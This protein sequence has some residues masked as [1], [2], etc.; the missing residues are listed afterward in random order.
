MTT[1]TET[2][3]IQMRVDQDCTI[4]IHD[5]RVNADEIIVGAT[6]RWRWDWEVE[7]GHADRVSNAYTLVWVELIDHGPGRTVSEQIGLSPPRDS[8]ERGPCLVAI[9]DLLAAAWETK[10]NEWNLNRAVAELQGRELG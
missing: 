7:Q 5:I 10:D 9:P 3:S 6:T 8:F 2:G 4:V 1:T